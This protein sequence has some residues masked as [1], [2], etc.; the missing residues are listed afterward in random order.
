MNA[1]ES[2]SNQAS[3]LVSLIA[4]STVA[5]VPLATVSLAVATINVVLYLLILKW[6][7]TIKNNPKCACAQDWKLNYIMFFPPVAII[8]A[9]VAVTWMASSSSISGPSG[10]MT[11]L[12]IGWII[13]IVS[14]YKYL[15]DLS[16]S[17][18]TCATSD[19]IGD[20]ALQVYTAVKVAWFVMLIIVTFAG[21]YMLRTV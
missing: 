12:A 19:M 1:V 13:L 16:V 11:L 15:N 21:S 20:E 4:K 7:M 10:L 3:P 6:G 9:L 2:I 14:G 5:H 8:T 17:K 18:C